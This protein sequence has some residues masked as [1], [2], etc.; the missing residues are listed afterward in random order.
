MCTP[1]SPTKHGDGTRDKLAAG[2][3]FVASINTKAQVKAHSGV[4]K[5]LSPRRHL[6]TMHSFDCLHQLNDAY[7]LAHRRLLRLHSSY[8]TRMTLSIHDEP[9]TTRELL[10]AQASI[11]SIST[12]TWFELVKV[13]YDAKSGALDSGTHSPT[14]GKT[15]QLTF[16]SA[17]R[18]AITPMNVQPAPR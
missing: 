16:V 6:L 13:H 9:L 5:Y 11:I 14:F 10:R 18:G 2:H 3:Y 8:S 7:H 4:S 17:V 12:N 15:Q 1:L